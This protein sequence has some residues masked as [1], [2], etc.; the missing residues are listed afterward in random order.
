MA[1]SPWV[2]PAFGFDDNPVES[3]EELSLVYSAAVRGQRTQRTPRPVIATS[4]QRV[5][6]AGVRHDAPDPHIDPDSV[7][8]AFEQM[9]E[10]FDVP[11]S[12]LVAV[13]R[14]ALAPAIARS[15]LV[16]VLA[17]DGSHVAMRFGSRVAIENADSIGMVPGALWSE[18]GVGTNAI[19]VTAKTGCASQVHGPEHWCVDQHEWSCSAAP[20]HNPSTGK[21]VAIIDISGPVNQ[22]H[23]AILGLVQSVAGQIELMLKN[24][25]DHKLGLL[26]AKMLPKFWHRNGPWVLCDTNG[27]VIGGSGMALKERY[28]LTCG[29]SSVGASDDSSMRIVSGIGPA[30][31]C[32]FDG[33]V[34]IVPCGA[35]K[36][37]PEYRLN[38]ATNTLTV[39]DGGNSYDYRL[40]AKHCAILVCLFAESRPVCADTLAREVWGGSANPVTVRAEVSRLRKKCPQLV[41]A[42]PYRLLANLILE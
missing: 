29:T 23:P 5:R 27:W 11:P 41:S 22:S 33:V 15:R 1:K 10:A 3:A 37:M 14:D 13:L 38:V 31:V 19:G 32:V 34:L 12:R 6:A 17:V 16:G 21:P 18:T 39:L 24:E 9:R 28:D 35:T 30:E 42:S 2:E 40:T 8:R 25:F 7:Q 20:I 4:W 36:T 26:R